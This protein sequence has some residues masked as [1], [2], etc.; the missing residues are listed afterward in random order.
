MVLDVVGSTPIARPIYLFF[1]M[2]QQQQQKTIDIP[3]NVA[4]GAYANDVLI[5]VTPTDIVFTFVQ[6]E[7]LEATKA[8]AV[9]RVV[10]TPSTAKRMMDALG[11][12]LKVYEEKMLE[13]K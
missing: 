4:V 3:S 12:Q 9:S 13:V 2:S 1:S 7:P 6:N 8:H 10:V 5:T 11:K